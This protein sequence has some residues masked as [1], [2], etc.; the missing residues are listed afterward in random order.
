MVLHEL[1]IEFHS[2]DAVNRHD[3]RPY[4]KESAI[5]TWAIMHLV[6]ASNSDYGEFVFH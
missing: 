5:F 3:L 1:D 4:V 6:L 2:F